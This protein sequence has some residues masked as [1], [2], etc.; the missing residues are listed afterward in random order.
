MNALSSMPPS[1]SVRLPFRAEDFVDRRLWLRAGRTAHA[2]ARAMR[3]GRTESAALRRGAD[4]LLHNDRIDDAAMLAKSACA[5][6]GRWREAP[7]LL[8]PDDT[9]YVRVRAEDDGP[10][11][12]ARDRGYVV[13]L[14]FAVV[15]GDGKP[16][17]WLGAEVWARG[18]DYHLDDHRTRPLEARESAKWGTRRAASFAWLRAHGFRGRIVAVDDREGDNWNSLSEAVE[19]GHE[20]VTRAEHNRRLLGTGRKLRQHLH[21]GPVAAAMELTVHDARGRGA[22]ATRVARVQV[23]WAEVTLRAPKNDRHAAAR[24]A[25][26][27]VRAIEVYERRAPRGCTPLRTYLLTTCPIAGGDDA[28]TIV[29]WYSDRWGV[30]VGNDLLK[31]ALEVERTVVRDVKAFRRQLALAGPIAAQV[32][33][34]VALARREAPPKV[35][36]VFSPRALREMREAADYFGARRPRGDWTLPQAIEVLARIGGADVRPDR[37]PGWRVVLRGWQRAT[38]FAA[39]RRF[40]PRGGSDDDD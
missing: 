2:M 32:A 35:T 18:D 15:P 34:W 23:R 21:R 20:V 17:A 1:A 38:E 12:T 33:E 24:A 40:R 10:L 25:T 16:S 37:P 36:E 8:V 28:A 3:Y 22:A 14:A 9:M 30:E 29:T 26:L 19:C 11:R 27:T 4:R 6:A 13:H 7:V 39:I 5:G 31:N